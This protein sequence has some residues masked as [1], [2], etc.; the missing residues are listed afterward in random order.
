MDIS[1]S[2]IGYVTSSFEEPIDMP[3]HGKTSTITVNEEFLEALE[4]IELN[5]HLWILSWFHKSKRSVLSTAP[6]RIDPD[7]PNFGVFGLRSPN[8]PNP[9]ALSLVK[10]LKVE[11][12]ILFLENFDA[13]DGT[14]IIDIKPYFEKDIIF[15][16]KT[17]DIR[18][19]SKEMKLNWFKMEALSHHQESCPD[20]EI[21]VRMAF[22]ADKH[23]G[24]ISDTS[25][26]IDIRGSNCLIDVLQGLTR[27]RFA[28]PS[29]LT[30]EPSD[31]IWTTSWRKNEET[32]IIS[33]NPLLLA[34]HSLEEI[35]ELE[36]EKLFTIQKK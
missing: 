33:F 15:S 21:A 20:L 28:S 9:V 23:L 1:I 26:K 18:P 34:E 5:S 16:P 25:I 8:R 29:R 11:D 4:K 31:D 13:I 19:A 12:N 2:P 32:L 6:N 30:I 35:A 22:I 10:L 36:D 7:L 24:K 14:P 27:A 3:I 17:P